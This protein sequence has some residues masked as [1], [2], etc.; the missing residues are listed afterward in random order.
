[1]AS[2]LWIKTVREPGLDARALVKE[3]EGK[4]VPRNSARK[5]LAVSLR[6]DFHSRE[7]RPLRL[8]LDYPR[9]LAVEEEKVIRRAPQ[10]R[11][12][13]DGH[14][15]P[16]VEIRGA[17]VLDD[18]PRGGEGYIDRGP[19]LLFWCLCHGTVSGGGHPSALNGRGSLKPTPE[20]P[21]LD[22]HR[23]R[24]YP[25]S[26][27]RSSCPRFRSPAQRGTRGP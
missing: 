26:L 4:A 5:G 20:T 22:L 1:A 7:G 14:S 23:N 2:G 9:G 11:E 19:R 21:P 27:R 16:R 18:P 8:G 24:C 15:A 25:P 6:L 10:Q 17:R 13:S 3:R 12:L